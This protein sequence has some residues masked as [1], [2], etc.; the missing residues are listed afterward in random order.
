MAGTDVNIGMPV[1]LRDKDNAGV[2][3]QANG[4]QR[5]LDVGIDVAGVQIDPRSIRAL[6]SADVVSAH[7][8]DATGTAFSALN[9]LPVNVVSSVVGDYINDY[10][11]ADNVAVGTPVNH[12]YLITA[13]KTMQLKKVWASGTGKIKIEV[14]I[15]PDGATF[16]SKFVAFNSEA[17]PNISIDLDFLAVLESGTGALIRIIK[18]NINDVTA[19]PFNIYS[20]ISGIEV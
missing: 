16:A 4:G 11:E 7:I 15:S 2:T 5:A 9:P 20:T 3:S 8:S 6:T 19:A 12:D 18:S 13:A 14:Q 10:D 1:S 17:N